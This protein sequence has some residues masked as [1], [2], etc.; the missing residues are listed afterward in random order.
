[1]TIDEGVPFTVPVLCAAGVAMDDG[2][3][4]ETFRSEPPPLPFTL[5]HGGPRT[6]LISTVQGHDDGIWSARG[7]FDL[8][9][10][11]I[12]AARVAA[13]HDIDAVS[14]EADSP[15]RERGEVIP[16]A[17]IR[18]AAQVPRGAFE[19]A[20]LIVDPADIALG[21]VAGGIRKAA[22]KYLSEIRN[23]NQ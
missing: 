2:R 8:S 6:G 22:D 23:L 15:R 12:L 7:R 13:S 19:H 18:A 5:Q 4:F 14:I 20:H 3:V 16:W 11:G 17:R 9:H 1:M 10:R 21:L